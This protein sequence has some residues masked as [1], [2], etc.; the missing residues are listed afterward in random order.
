M[1][2]RTINIIIRREYLNKVKK[3]SFLIITFLVPIL[4]VALCILPTLIMMGTKESAKDI[5]VVDKSG[6]VLT[7]AW[8]P[9][10]ASPN[11]MKRTRRSLRRPS[12]RNPWAWI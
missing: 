10:S 4:F 11:W 5:A 3:K 1:N 9:S 12:P 6:I 7:S 8:M 2:L